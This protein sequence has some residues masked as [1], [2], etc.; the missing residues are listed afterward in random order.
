VLP[1]L[2]V[3]LLAQRDR[4]LDQQ[5][6][7][8]DVAPSETERFA[9]TKAGIGKDGD[10]RRVAGVERYAHRLDRRRRKWF[11]LLAP[12]RPR[13]LHAPSRIRRDVPAHECMLQDRAEQ[14][15]R[16]P[17]RNRTRPRCQPV[18]LPAPDDLWRDFPQSDRP[19]VRTEVVVVE[20][21][22][23]KPRLRGERRGMRRGP[24]FGHVFAERLRAGVERCETSGP[25]LP[26]DLCVKV[27]RIAA[28]AE[29]PCTVP[30]VLPPP[31]TPHD[32]ATGPRYLLDAH[33]EPPRRPGWLLR[34]E[35][36]GARDQPPGERQG[37]K[38][39]AGA[40]LHLA[41]RAR[42]PTR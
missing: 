16:M 21:R 17:N 10:E 13:L 27:A 22:V 37:A 6:L 7:L 32:F 14:I 39:G 38:Q 23:V 2:R 33:R 4:P 29:R 26:T 25:T 42:W 1:C 15:H 11:H 12:R 20:A 41:A 24:R 35:P 34:T 31:H 36:S 5:G 30:A 9:R 40:S 28:G 19:E 8:A 18:G 3:G